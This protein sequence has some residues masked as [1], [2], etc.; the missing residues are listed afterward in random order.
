MDYEFEIIEASGGQ[1]EW[2]VKVDGDVVAYSGSLHE[3]KAEAKREVVK[4]SH[5]FHN[6]DLPNALDSNDGIEG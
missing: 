4:V 3:T 2:V 6:V 1:Y 5:A